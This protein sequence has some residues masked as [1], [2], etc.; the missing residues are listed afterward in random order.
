MIIL[1]VELQIFLIRKLRNMLGVASRIMR[2][3]RIGK[4]RAN[5]LITQHIVR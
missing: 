2:I 1:A 4:Q 3:D 5:D